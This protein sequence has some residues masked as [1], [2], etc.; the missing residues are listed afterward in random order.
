[1]YL[2]M[3]KHLSL[4]IY[5]YLRISIFRMYK[6]IN[7]NLWILLVFTLYLFSQPVF[8]SNEITTEI[9]DVL[10]KIEKDGILKIGQDGLVNKKQENYFAML[11]SAA[12]IEELIELTSHKNKIVRCYAFC[13]LTHYHTAD[14]FSVIL[15]HID[16]NEYVTLHFHDTIQDMKVGDFFIYVATSKE[17]FSESTKLTPEQ[18]ISLDSL[19]I[20]IPNKLNSRNKA[21]MRVKPVSAL[22]PRIREL[23]L[24]DNNQ[25][26][27]VALAKYR[28]EKDIELILNN[29]EKIDYEKLY[30]DVYA[31]ISED[32]QEICKK[33]I[34]GF[35]YTYIAIASYPNSKFFPLLKKNLL[36][37]LGNSFWSEDWRNLYKAVAAFKDKEA[38]MLLQ[39]PLSQVKAGGS[40]RK[41]HLESVCDALLLFK[42]PIYDELIWRLWTEEGI[43]KLEGFNYLFEK[44]PDKV[45]EVS[46]IWLGSP[47]KPWDSWE[48]K[49]LIKEIL[50]IIFIKDKDLAIE[51][52]KKN[53]RNSGVSTFEVFA[54]KIPEVKD[55]SI[56]IEPL[57]DRL[58]FESNPHINLR[59]VKILISFNDDKVNKRILDVRD[60]NKSLQSGWGEEVLNKILKNNNLIR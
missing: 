56:F 49:S 21:L 41:Y 46:K 39:L 8:G 14:L 38:L 37:A 4:M 6:M 31:L 26:A 15:N 10:I 17:S 22:Y 51:I 60:E 16:D 50:N 9:A 2:I 54:N 34:Q 3:T 30:G 59:I 18:I 57:F 52:I 7:Q 1:M 11:K 32:P 19:L 13:V 44:F 23:Y 5:G 40:V 43:V 29:R 53:I 27:L 28:K 48:F 55:N 24:K 20:K 58:G 36:K 25:S 45:F 47:N 35:N 12:K 33:E 42:D